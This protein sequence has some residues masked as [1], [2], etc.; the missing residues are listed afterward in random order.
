M[1]SLDSDF[2]IDNRGREAAGID[3]SVY[4]C[5]TLRTPLLV[6]MQGAKHLVHE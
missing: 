4:C 3:N 2:S 5:R 1:Y 6:G